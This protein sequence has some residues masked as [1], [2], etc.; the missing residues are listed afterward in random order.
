MPIEKIKAKMDAEILY[1][2]TEMDVEDQYEKIVEEH[3]QFVNDYDK[4]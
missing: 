1:Y 3:W 4:T 2:R